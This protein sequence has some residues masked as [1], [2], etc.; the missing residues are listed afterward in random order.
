MQNTYVYDLFSYKI[1][2]IPGSSASLGMA[3]N[4]K[5]KEHFMRFVNVA[6]L[7]ST[8]FHLNK[9]CIFFE[10]VLITTKLFIYSSP[11]LRVSEVL[12]PGGKAAGG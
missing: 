10:Y 7:H 11:I 1:L 9:C 2:H 5:L 12:S 4:R 3:V 6:V 8:T